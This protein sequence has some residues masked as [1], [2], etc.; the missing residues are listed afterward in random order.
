[1]PV[2][3]SIRR[4]RTVFALG[5]MLALAACGQG[6]P[7]THG[8][9]LTMRRLTESQYRQAIA[10][11]FGSD[12]KVTGQFE[13]DIRKD[14]LLAVGTSEIVVTRTAFEH[15]E[16]I[17]R[18]VAAQVLDESRR[19]KTVPCR[20]V[21]ESQPDEACASQFIATVGRRLFR[22]PLGRE[23]LDAWVGAADSAARMSGNFYTGLKSVLTTMLL[24][25][26]FL[27]RIDVAEPDPDAHG[28][29]RLDSYSKAARLSFLLWNA[30]PDDALLDAAQRGELDHERGLARQVD[31]MMGSPRVGDGIRAFFSDFLGFDSFSTLEKDPLI[32][33]KFSQELAADARE[34]TLRVI[35]D[36]LVNRNGDY[37]DLFTTRKSFM[38]RALGAV[39]AVPVSSPHGWEPY[40]FPPG[41]P[42]AGLLAEVSFTA[43]HAHPGRSSATIR[44]KAVRELLLCEPVPAPPNNV[45]FAIVVDT[46]NPLYKTARDRLTAHRTDP[47]CAGCHRIIDPIGLALEN[48]DGVGQYRTT[49]NGTPI[50]ASGELDG[51]KFS[52]A[53]GLGQAL[54][55][56]PATV[57]CLAESLY[58]YAV[59]RKFQ[60]GD[61]EWRS[62]LKAQFAAD[63]YRVTDLLRLIAMS[64]AFYKVSE[65][66]G[67]PPAPREAA[68]G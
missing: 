35:V 53:A 16:E 17:A 68:A 62:W 12:I 54:H 61:N 23:K 45:N 28:S 48:F 37:R 24:A 31:R 40:E 46:K 14:G 50:D 47:V 15:Y 5:V 2:V 3:Q 20:P 38:T 4:Y 1:M 26:D 9:P 51:F 25:P 21:A 22:R 42:R 52:D 57:S 8:N 67:S 36:H 27:F 33:P 43:L 56:D 19:A 11:I 6:E 58:R 66:G 29:V 10:D 34:Q 49:E 59:G 60:P 55:D 41:D 63:G 30:T 13:P 39:Y 64:K 44:G 32:Y 7:E 65:P 18:N